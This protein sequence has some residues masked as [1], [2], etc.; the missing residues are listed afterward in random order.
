VYGGDQARDLLGLPRGQS[1]KLV[2]GRSGDYEVYV[3]STS[4]NRRLIPGTQVLYY[5]ATP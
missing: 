1:I 5:E 3:Q 2:P 4:I